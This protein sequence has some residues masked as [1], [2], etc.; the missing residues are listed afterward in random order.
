MGKRRDCPWCLER[1]RWPRSLPLR[2]DWRLRQRSSLSRCLSKPAGCIG[3]RAPH[4]SG[5]AAAL[6]V[7]PLQAVLGTAFFADATAVERRTL[8]SAARLCGLC[9]PADCCVAR[10]G[11]IRGGRRPERSRLDEII[12]GVVLRMADTGDVSDASHQAR[13]IL[14]VAPELLLSSGLVRPGACR[15]P[16][17]LHVRA[18]RSS[19]GLRFQ[20][21]G[22]AASGCRFERRLHSGRSTGLSRS[23]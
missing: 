10:R 2:V 21:H 17:N 7:V 13:K 14:G 22:G 3:P 18:R 19:P 8:A 11:R 5:T 12:D 1:W 9:R 20:T 23:R 16:D 6:A 4:L 15:R